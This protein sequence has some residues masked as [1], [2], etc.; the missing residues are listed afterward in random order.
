MTYLASAAELTLLLAVAKVPRLSRESAAAGLVQPLL[1]FTQTAELLLR[2]KW[3]VSKNLRY[4]GGNLYKRRLIPTC[5]VSYYPAPEDWGGLSFITPPH[6]TLRE[7]QF[8]S[9]SQQRGR[10]GGRKGG[11]GGG[12]SVKHGAGR[13]G[14]V[15][16]S[17]YPVS[18]AILEMP[19]HEAWAQIKW[20][21]RKMH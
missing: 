18:P 3:R 16:H 19:A 8:V 11:G 12:G 1:G 4:T 5:R 9:E 10:A 13:V 7:N 15:L 14:G 6:G 21:D 2:R 20:T 17:G